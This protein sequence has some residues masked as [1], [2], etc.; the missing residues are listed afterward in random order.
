MPARPAWHVRVPDILA[1]VRDGEGVSPVFDRAAFERLFH[2]SRRQAIRLMELMGGYQAG[3]TYLVDRGTLV[4]YLDSLNGAG[5]V[6]RATGRRQRILATLE[7]AAQE[8]KSR[9]IVIQTKT[10][11]DSGPSS[12]LPQGVQRVGLDRIQIQYSSATELLSRIVD[13][14]SAAAS[15]FEAFQRQVE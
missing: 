10:S 14:A 13:L 3:R 1:A 11:D 4:S 8:R 2:V 15:D 9:Q 5:T 12:S 7:A 6:T